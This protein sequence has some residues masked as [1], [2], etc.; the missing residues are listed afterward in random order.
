[1]IK[2]KFLSLAAFALV[3]V[4]MTSCSSDDDIIDE[5]QQPGNKDNVVTMTTTISRSDIAGTRA[6]SPD[7]VKTFAAGD[8]IAVVYKNTSNEMVMVKSQAL[9]E[10]DYDNTATFTVTLTNPKANGSLKYIYPAAMAN[11][12]GSINYDALSTQD[13]TLANIAANLDLALYEGNMTSGAGLPDNVTLDNQLT[14]TKFTI[15]NDGGTDITNS[16]TSLKVSDGTNNYAVTPSSLSNIWVAMLPVSSGNVVYVGATAGGNGYGKSVMTTGLSAG[17]IYPINVTMISNTTLSTLKSG[18]VENHGGG[19]FVMAT[20][21]VS[22]APF[23]AIGRVAYIG[24][25]VEVS[26]PGSRILVMALTDVGS[27]LWKNS[28]S[29]GESD[30]NDQLARNGL[31]F[32]AKHAYPAAYNAF[33]WDTSRPEGASKWFLPSKG[34]FT[35]MLPFGE[36]EGI[37]QLTVGSYWTATEAPPG[38]APSAWFYRV[39]SNPKDNKFAYSVKTYEYKVRACFAY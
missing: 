12:D 37:G 33:N 34:Q 11:A 31:D 16:V 1:M 18:S 9:P 36:P 28:P 20:G 32:C 25:G 26:M 39:A 17:H 15:K 7:G 10:G 6:L 19:D 24:A 8:K 30:Y 3:S 22:K 35:V 14:I 5:P 29:D 27:Y 23:D 38:S 21:D 13:G 2:L 4:V